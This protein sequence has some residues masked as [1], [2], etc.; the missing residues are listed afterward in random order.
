ME[1]AGK[2]RGT[3]CIGPARRRCG[4]CGAVAYCSVSHQVPINFYFFLYI[5]YLIFCWKKISESYWVRFL[6][7]FFN[8]FPIGVIIKES[9]KG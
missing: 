7:L 4:R 9:V 5:N 3:R 6:F 1:C 8:R 2:G